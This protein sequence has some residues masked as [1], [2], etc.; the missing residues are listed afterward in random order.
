[1]LIINLRF[2]T[3]LTDAEN[4]FRA[5][6]REIARSLKLQEDIAT[7]EQEMV[8]KALRMGHS[9]TEVPSHEYQRWFGDSRIKLGKVW[10][11]FIYT[12]IKYCLF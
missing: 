5:I 4:G 6:R 9:I 12:A 8:I 11:R 2:G 7:I 1:M 3:T 10:F